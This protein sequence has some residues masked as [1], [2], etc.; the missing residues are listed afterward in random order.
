MTASSSVVP[1]ISNFEDVVK[2]RRSVRGFLPEPVPEDVIHKVFALAQTSPSNC[3]IQPWKVS[4]ASGASCK[5]LSAKFV[6]TV[7]AGVESNPDQDRIYTFEGIYRKRQIDT[8]AALYGN[9]DIARNDIDGRQRAAL[10]N[11]EFF[12]APHAAFIA[13]K[14]EF[15]ETVALDVGMYAQNLMLAM[16]A[17]GIGSC[18]Q[19]SV[20]RYPDIIREHFGLDDSW[21]MMMGIS[22]G[23]E[24]TTVAANKTIVPRASIEDEVTFVE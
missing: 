24:D 13:M 16:T 22:F 19:A 15:G 4:V 12:G 21:A 3:N 11:F 9:M 5:A 6:E 14:R 17:Y 20:S 7:S 2:T 23:Y 8:A 10:R 1:L 18:A